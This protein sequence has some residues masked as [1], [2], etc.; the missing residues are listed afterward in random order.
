MGT[1][2]YRLT[3]QYNQVT[4]HSPTFD[5]DAL[6]I[7]A[8]TGLIAILIDKN[9]V[10]GI[11]YQD[12]S[13]HVVLGIDLSN[14]SGSTWTPATAGNTF[15]G[16]IQLSPAGGIV[17]FI[18]TD[19]TGVTIADTGSGILA[20]ARLATSGLSHSLPLGFWGML[21]AWEPGSLPGTVGFPFDAYALPPDA[22]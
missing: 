2:D 17:A 15:S 3:I 9:V 7:S 22:P 13:V 20:R 1:A 14:D 10:N 5:S 4:A 19:V 18:S 12:A 16:G 8:T 21:A 6:T 11:N